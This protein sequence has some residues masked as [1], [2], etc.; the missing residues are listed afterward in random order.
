MD[1]DLTYTINVDAEQ[2]VRAEAQVEQ[3]FT[4]IATEAKKADTALS[5][6]QRTATAT[7]AAFGSTEAAVARGRASLAA[8]ARAGVQAKADIEKLGGVQRMTSAEIEKSINVIGRATRA[9]ETLGRSAPEGLDRLRTRLVAMKG[10]NEEMAASSGKVTAAGGLQAAMLSRLTGAFAGYLSVGAILGAIKSTAAYADTLQTTAARTGLTVEAV[11]RLGYA[12]RQNGTNLDR[13]TSSLN[14]MQD[15]LASGNEQASAALS[16]LGLSMTLLAQ[17]QP[18]QQLFAISDALKSVG[19]HNEKIAILNDLFGRGGSELLPLFN[20][21]MRKTAE[22]ADRMGQVID[23]ST[24]AALARMDD[25]IE[26]VTIAG[27]GMI[28]N[29]LGPLLPYLEGATQQALALAGAW[30]QLLTGQANISKIG[31]FLATA[32]QSGNGMGLLGM[33]TPQGIAAMIAASQDPSFGNVTSG[34]SSTGDLRFE[35]ADKVV[36]QLNTKLGTTNRLTSKSADDADRMAVAFAKTLADIRAMESFAGKPAYFGEMVQGWSVDKENPALAAMLDFN[37]LMRQQ[38][39]AAMPEGRMTPF[40]VPVSLELAMDREIAGMQEA[41]VRLG[42]TFGQGFAN[43][44]ADLMP[45]A[46]LQAVTGGGSLAGGM[47]SAVGI[48]IGKGIVGTFSEEFADTFLGKT[49]GVLLPGVGA[50]LGPLVESWVYKPSMRANDMRDQFISEN[51][52]IESLNRRAVEA[53]GNLSGLLRA[54]NPE[55]LQRAIEDLTRTIEKAELQRREDL[56]ALGGRGLINPNAVSAVASRQGFLGGEAEK[57]ALEQF[58]TGNL[59]RAGAGFSSFLQS[60]GQVT[61]GNAA[62]FGAGVA[63]IFGEMVGS[64]TSTL[65]A[66]TTLR[67]I[68]AG[69]QEQFAALGVTGGEAFAEIAALSA[70]AADEGVAKAVGQVLALNDVMIGLQNVGLLTEETFDALGLTVVETFEK[71]V[72]EGK[73]GDAAL[74]LMQPTLQTIWELQQDFGYSV[75]ETTQ[76]LLDQAAAAGLVGDQFRSA[77]ERMTAALE[78]LVDRL[79]IIIAK[80]FGIG[81][82]AQSAAEDANAAFDSIEYPDPNVPNG[83]N[84]PNGA[85]PTG[86]ATGGYVTPYGVQYRALGGPIGSDT[87]PAWLTPGEFVMRKSA[88]DRIGADTLGA[89]NSGGGG[90]TSTTVNVTIQAWDGTDVA[91]VVKSREFADAFVEGQGR[92]THQLR[93]RTRAALGVS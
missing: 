61:A 21:E 69:L 18:D 67:P 63:G 8:F 45:T 88:V 55:K 57:A 27:R 92:N 7:G 51:G 6:V 65:D 37:A 42:Q 60:G 50:L 84:Y 83:G 34:A 40:G 29:F 39:Q 46:I 81:D 73:N 15:R 76:K 17:M 11:Q 85:D 30:N 54:D 26:N 10:A 31:Q 22:S 74:R 9:Y 66:L 41:G 68:L 89:M 12:A 33:M 78:R 1:L 36:G 64:G 3:G 25:A 24:V 71:L 79:D 47:G 86:S 75:D 58:L 80:M 90:S 72:G 87:V 20:S 14:L 93:T 52:G 38:G 43:E 53:G 23:A 32:G 82:A 59:G 48:S 91:R 16:K 49:L 19:S 2:A 77:E 56:R 13:L 62:G 70:F 44:F 4:K 5:G 28:A 35:M